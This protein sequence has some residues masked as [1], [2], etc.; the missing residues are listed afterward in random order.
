MHISR[1]LDESNLL[2]RPSAREEDKRAWKTIHRSKPDSYKT[3][4][5][6]SSSS[7]EDE[8]SD[9]DSAY[10]VY[11]EVPEHVSKSDYEN[12][13][14]DTAGKPLFNPDNMKNPH[15]ADGSCS[16]IP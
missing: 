3:S 7:S 8:E 4:S 12:V 11:S 10:S 13:I 1:K 5:D 14:T 6:N 2:K 15:S 9:A 16:Q